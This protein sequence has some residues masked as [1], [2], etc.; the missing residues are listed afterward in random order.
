MQKI[1]VD[2]DNTLW[3]FAT[4]LWKQLRGVNSDFPSPSK[5]NEWTFWKQYLADNQFYKAVRE[6]HIQQDKFLPYPDS[7]SFLTALKE[8]G[9]WIIIASHR[10]KEAMDVTVRWLS[11]WELPFDDV[12]IGYE[13]SILFKNS[14]AVIDD[15]PEVLEK[16]FQSGILRSGLLHPWNDGLNHPLFP[17][18]MEVFDYIDSK[19]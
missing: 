5:W 7:K 18:L 3:D 16:A 15:S 12:Y 9:F 13:K 11:K 6:I 4:A 17:S 10:D 19:E 8:K 2:I 14:Y 1:I